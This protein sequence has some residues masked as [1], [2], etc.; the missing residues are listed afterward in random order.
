MKQRL[1]DWRRNE[2]EEDEEYKARYP[3]EDLSDRLAL[4]AIDYRRQY[5]SIWA[6]VFGSFDTTTPIGPMCFNSE[7]VPSHAQVYDTLQIF[8]VRIKEIRQGLQWPLHVFGVIAARDSVDHNRNIIFKR[9]RDN[10]QT[11]TQEDPCLLLTGP[12][13]AVVVCDPVYFE[14][15]LKVEGSIKSEDKDLS[16][17]TVPLTAAS[18][19]PHT[20]LFSKDYTS[21]LSTLELAY[22]YVVNSMEATIHVHITEESWP[23][24]TYGQFTAHTSSLRDEEILLLDS[25]CEKMIVNDDGMIKLSRCVASVEA[26][27]ELQVSVVAF[28]RDNDERKIKVVGNDDKDFTPKKTGKSTGTLNVGFCKMDVTVYWSL[29]SLVSAECPTKSDNGHASSAT[30]SDNGHASSATKSDDGH[31]SSDTKSGNDHASSDLCAVAGASG[32]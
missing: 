16:L 7:P 12:T 19:I 6:R 13:R 11:L 14:V 5:E 21:R 23:D 31:A 4:K 2:K 29:L 9:E 18:Y 1:A 27:G 17:L 32:V 25:R 22:G 24:G 3:N 20:C 8:S 10:C 15:A 28:G 30:K 26:E